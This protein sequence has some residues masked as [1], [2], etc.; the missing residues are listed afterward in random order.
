MWTSLSKWQYG[1]SDF[2][3]LPRRVSR[4]SMLANKLAHAIAPVGGLKFFEVA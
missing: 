1:A 4:H 3:Q 2:G